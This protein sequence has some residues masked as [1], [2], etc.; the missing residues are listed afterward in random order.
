LMR[1]SGVLT[2]DSSGI[3]SGAGLLGYVEAVTAACS[4]YNSTDTSGD[5]IV[6]V[7]ADTGVSF[8]HP[9][10]YVDLDIVCA[11]GGT[12]YVHATHLT[13]GGF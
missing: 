12:A 3:A 4:V 11:A 2:T 7:P 8:S 1:T 13:S 9:V 5:L 10:K 6:T